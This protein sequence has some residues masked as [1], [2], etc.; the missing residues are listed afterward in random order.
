MNIKKTINFTS[1]RTEGPSALELKED[2]VI[3]LKAKS[4]MLCIVR[5]E[6]LLEL[7]KNHSPFNSIP[8]EFF[9][10]ANPPRFSGNIMG[11]SVKSFL[12][13][14][15]ESSTEKLQRLESSVEQ[16][17]AELKTLKEKENGTDKNK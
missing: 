14:N 15:A 6:F 1:L 8:S 16:I 3:Q 4:E 9:S 10:L 13:N 17:A 11:S 12:S 5:Q 7:L 2:E